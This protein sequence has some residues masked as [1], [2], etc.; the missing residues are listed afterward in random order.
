MRRLIWG[1]AGRTYHIVGNLMS[2]LICEYS[3]TATHCVKRPLTK[4]SKIVFKTDY[5]LIQVKSI[6]ECS[7]ESILQYFRLSLSYQL[8][9]RSLFCLLLIGHSTQV[10]LYRIK[11]VIARINICQVPREML[12]YKA[13]PTI[14]SRPQFQILL[15]FSP[16]EPKA[17]GELI[18][19]DLSRRPSVRLSVS[20][21]IH[22]MNISET[23]WPIII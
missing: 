9:L 12:T 20:S 22:Y 5:C 17:L 13:P 7:K 2:R 21:H 14:C 8:S 11:H 23:S 4:R 6:A 15:L 19:W 18:G 1:F 16:P 10:L 3:K